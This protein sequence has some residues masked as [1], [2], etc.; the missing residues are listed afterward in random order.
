MRIITDTN[1]WYSIAD[2]KYSFNDVKHLPLTA[3]ALNLIE[4]ISSP[5][6]NGPDSYKTVLKTCRVIKRFNPHF[7][8]MAPYDFA[9]REYL[10][11]KLKKKHHLSSFYKSCEEGISDEQI[12]NYTSLRTDRI[13]DFK[14]S[15][16]AQIIFNKSNPEVLSQ[17]RVAN[18]A[19]D[20]A[21]RDF[22]K[23]LKNILS[24]NIQN[25]DKNRI[26][27]KGK[28]MDLYLRARAHYNQKLILEKNY[29]PA[30]N[31]QL[32]LANLLYVREGDLYWTTDN[33]WI[34]II[35]TVN[36]GHK[37]FYKGQY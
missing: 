20:S 12:K 7:N 1:I 13:N 37:L 36:M 29:L 22:L 32:D 30:G 3:T 28:G 25:I 15:L 10:G 21:G 11:K 23:E 31:D 9:A 2:G 18:D 34:N 26:L 24:I 16:T 5:G 33:K 35:N 6:L 14:N 17:L 19:A 27:R 4:L 8:L